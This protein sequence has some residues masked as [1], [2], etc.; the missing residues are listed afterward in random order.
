[1]IR[2]LYTAATGM[3]AQQQQVDITA[4]NIANVNTTSFKKDR[5]E[6]KDL[7]YDQLNF[8]NGAT[9]ETTNN[10]KGIDVGLGV[11]ISAIH[12]EFK[13]GNLIETGNEFDMAINGSGFFQ[14]TMP[15]GEIAYSRDGTFT[16][17]SEGTLVNS[18]GYPVEPEIVVP[19][20]MSE[21]SIGLDGTISGVDSTSGETTVLGNLTLVNFVNPAGLKPLGDNLYRQS[22]VSG[23]ATEQTPGTNGAGTIVQGFLEASNVQLVKEMVD[24]I[25]G[26]RAYEANSKSITTADSMLQTINQLKRS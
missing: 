25:T 15:D 12:K 17:D 11:K 20:G 8:T 5:A 3:V 1:M 21:I 24:L 2:S 4:N 7:L 23:D 19:D 26:Q 18:S 10:P 14:I 22:S 6:F 13:V 9:S 16:L